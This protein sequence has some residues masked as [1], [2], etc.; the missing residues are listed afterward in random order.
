[1]KLKCSKSRIEQP[2]NQ[3]VLDGKRT[4]GD[5][6]RKSSAATAGPSKGYHTR[7]WLLD[8]HA[9]CLVQ[10]SAKKQCDM[11]IKHKERQFGLKRLSFRAVVSGPQILLACTCKRDAEHFCWKAA[12][13][14]IRWR[15]DSSLSRLLRI[16]S[17]PKCS[18]VKMEISA[19]RRVVKRVPAKLSQNAR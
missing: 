14:R 18:N 10:P 13:H 5:N 6:V 11:P 17:L 16:L 15:C 1:M 12:S 2:S 3:I 19:P 9:L 7:S 4:D 8:L